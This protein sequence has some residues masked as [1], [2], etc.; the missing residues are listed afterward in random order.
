M[1]A[2][3]TSPFRAGQ[4]LEIAFAAFRPRITFHSDQELTMEIIAGD[5]AGFKDTVQYEATPMRDGLV[6]LSWQ[7]HIGSTVVHV[8]DIEASQTYTLI[9]PAKGG[10][11]RLV[12]RIDRSVTL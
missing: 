10:F 4:V 8:L 9:T 11:I 5:N 3:G 6:V 7:E 1:I 2:F 12:G